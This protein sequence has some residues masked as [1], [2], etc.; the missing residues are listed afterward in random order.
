MRLILFVSEKFKFIT[1]NF[2]QHRLQ[3]YSPPTTW[4]LLAPLP[5]RRFSSRNQFHDLLVPGTSVLPI[6]LLI[7][8]LSSKNVNKFL[9]INNIRDV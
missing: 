9:Q 5:L 3:C 4:K 7:L 2:T 1:L 6:K 8:M